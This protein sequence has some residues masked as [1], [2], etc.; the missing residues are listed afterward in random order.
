[1][2][3]LQEKGRGN[4]EE[5]VKETA[6]KTVF[7]KNGPTHKVDACA[8]GVYQALFSTHTIINWKRAPGDEARVT[9]CKVCPLALCCRRKPEAHA[10][11]YHC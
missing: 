10:S 7:F 5:T 9:E 1:M 6:K 4:N 8:H 3:W 2:S 11:F